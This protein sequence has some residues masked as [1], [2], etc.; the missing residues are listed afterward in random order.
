MAPL[1]FDDDLHDLVPVELPAAGEWVELRPR[2]S[3]RA[4]QDA[5][6][7][8]LAGM[9]LDKS[10]L[11][12]AAEGNLSQLD[13]VRALEI[14]F[15]RALEG[16]TFALLERAIARWRLKARGEWVTETEY[17][18]TAE[19]VE[20]LDSESF[21]AIVAVAN[22]LYGARTEGER[23]DLSESGADSSPP[24]AQLRA[25]SSG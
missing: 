9:T 4:A 3:K 16:G 11:A 5:Q 20:A 12:G 22:R 1:I 15:E 25:I 8:T 17:P 6:R 14:D 24:A 13:V 23:R 19:N 18:I 21:D 2:L 10:A 7:A